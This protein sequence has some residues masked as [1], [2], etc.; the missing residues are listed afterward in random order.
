MYKGPLAWMNGKLVPFNKSYIMQLKKS[1][2]LPT[3]ISQIQQ[4]IDHGY[5]PPKD[6]LTRE[7]FEEFTMTYL[8]QKMRKHVVEYLVS[9]SDREKFEIIT[10][11]NFTPQISS[12]EKKELDYELKYASSIIEPTKRLEELYKL[13]VKIDITGQARS[14][15]LF[16]Q[17]REKP[18][19]IL[20]EKIKLLEK[21]MPNLSSNFTPHHLANLLTHPRFKSYELELEMDTLE[22]LSKF[23]NEYIAEGE[24]LPLIRRRVK[25][26][27][28]DLFIYSK[29]HYDGSVD[30]TLLTLVKVRDINPRNLFAE[31]KKRLT[32]RKK[33][34]FQALNDVLEAFD[35]QEDRR[36]DFLRT[37]DE[38]H[39][40]LYVD[41]YVGPKG[42]NMLWQPNFIGTVHMETLNHVIDTV[43]EIKPELSKADLNSF[44]NI[45][46][47]VKSVVEIDESLE[48]NILKE[49]LE[50]IEK[51]LY[52]R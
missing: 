30:R 23:T 49:V 40:I 37:L 21:Y 36:E 8:N 19:D 35:R 45:E 24:I 29:K 33:A 13:L 16:V 25:D 51:K 12:E 17:G 15:L 50:N 20:T 43:R 39:Q 48:N 26:L 22:L 2:E 38:I 10:K 52:E 3:F 47:Q 44:E 28:E 9:K 41:K 46:R 4:A 14:Y 32:Q 5:S 34:Y 11:K 7:K 31:H 6:L 1:N 27:P 42:M 18:G